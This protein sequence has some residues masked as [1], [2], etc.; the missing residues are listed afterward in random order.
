MSRSTTP[1]ARAGKPPSA[2]GRLVL[3]AALVT[4]L[5]LPAVAAGAPSASD[6]QKLQDQLKGLQRD[7]QRAGDAYSEA[8]WQL[9]ATR[10]EAARLD[11]EIATAADELAAASARLSERAVEMYRSGGADYLVVLL[12]S[13]DF[14]S[15][16]VRLEYFQRI[17]QQ[18]ADV[19]DAVKRLQEQLR[20]D[21]AALD[22]VLRQQSEDAA[23]LKR[24]AER[25]EGRLK[26]QQS[27]YD[28][29]K[30]ELDAAIAAQR[31][32]TG[33]TTARVGPNGMVFP[34]AG[35]NY[36]TDTWGAA[37]SG[38][39]THQGTDI[40]AARGTPCVA[41]LGGT[42]RTQFNALGGYTIWLTA[43]NGWAFYYAH[44]DS[45]AVTAGR[46]R[47]GQ[48]IAYVGS[49]GNASESAPHLH[50]EIHPNGG[51]AVNP[52]PYLIQMQ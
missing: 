2:L 33:T 20:V 43:D 3:A 34:V 29:L 45:Y 9:D 26:Q 21:R 35:P 22:D 32:T 27:E 37:R 36:F 52:Y 49:T 50:F 23:R 10:V 6:V 7:V 18:D 13:T 28:R 16:L 12:S 1:S 51:A 4:S 48:V 46:V 17:G 47:A 44:L 42:V 14:D 5:V 15:M 8:Y 30:K 25:I 19:I 38:G 40:M 41:V 31:A 39:R 11:R 24:E